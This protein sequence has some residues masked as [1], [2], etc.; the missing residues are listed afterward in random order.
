MKK[1]MILM[2]SLAVLFSFAAC[3]NSSNTPADTDEPTTGIL[4]SVLESAFR[5]VVAAME[6]TTDKSDIVSL[7]NAGTALTVDSKNVVVSSDYTT[8]TITKELNP[9]GEALDAEV[10][11]LVVTGINTSAESDNGTS[12]APYEITLDTFAYTYSGNVLKGGMY[13]PFSAI[14]N[15]YFAGSATADVVVD[16]QTKAATTYTVSNTSTLS[17]VLP[18]TSTGISLVV[19]GEDVT[20]KGVVFDYLNTNIGAGYT[21]Y[22]KYVKDNSE[23]YEKAIKGYVDQL[24]DADAATA[25]ILGKLNGWIASDPTTQGSATASAWKASYA[26]GTAT[27]T[28]TPLDYVV[29]SSA[30]ATTKDNLEI[31]I[32]Q[33]NPITITFSA[34]KAPGAAESSFNA[35]TYTISGNFNARVSNG[36]AFPTTGGQA[37][38]VNLAGDVNTADGENLTIAFSGS[39]IKQA[40]TLPTTVAN[41]EFELGETSTASAVV[42][43][44]PV[45]VP[46]TDAETEVTTVTLQTATVNVDY[47]D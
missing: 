12:S 44:G 39:E 35:A 1:F 13:V 8:L 36:T 15:G 28:F 22:A 45:L 24:V 42:E 16:S 6:N 11:T 5:D 27:F 29:I 7:L 34:E 19:D 37:F 14:V 21:T 32:A 46:E 33:G 25:N 41:L 23:K 20:A 30:A 4:D 17:V 40:I 10:V 43:M 3:D 38:T 31:G 2:L 26:N 9:A 18:Q 47:A